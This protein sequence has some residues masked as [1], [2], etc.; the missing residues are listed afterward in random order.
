MDSAT[1]YLI[2]VG[3]Y[4]NSRGKCVPLKNAHLKWV[5]CER[6]CKWKDQVCC[7][8]GHTMAGDKKEEK[9]EEE[10]EAA[11]ADQISE[12]DAA[13]I[14]F[15]DGAIRLTFFSTMLKSMLQD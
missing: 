13:W 9:A 14:T 5:M 12:Q 1:H 2:P 15:G 11:A 8:M 3:N 10:D 7:K 4:I 6:K